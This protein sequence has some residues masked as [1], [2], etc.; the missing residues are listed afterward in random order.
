MN[1]KGDCLSFRRVADIERW[2][3]WCIIYWI[4]LAS[5]SGDAISASFDEH[6]NVNSAPTEGTIVAPISQTNTSLSILPCLFLFTRTYILKMFLHAQCV[7]EDNK[8]RRSA[9]SRTTIVNDFTGIE[10]TTQIRY[11]SLYVRHFVKLWYSSRNHSSPGCHR[12]PTGPGGI[13]KT[14]E[15]DYQHPILPIQDLLFSHC[16]F[17]CHFDLIINDNVSI[18]LPFVSLYPCGS[19]RRYRREIKQTTCHCLIEMYIDVYTERIL[20]C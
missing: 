5:N 12:K 11:R 19:M 4:N 10:L 13:S 14:N 3:L 7:S 6:C 20:S 9:T 2:S 15:I 16:Q 8:R 18:T 17:Y 1:Q